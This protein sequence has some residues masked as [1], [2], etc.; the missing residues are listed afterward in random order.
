[1]AASSNATAPRASARGRLRAV[2]EASS[3]RAVHRRGDGTSRGLRATWEIGR[4]TPRVLGAGRSDGR[5]RGGYGCPH[6]LR[7]QQAGRGSLSASAL[8]KGADLLL[9]LLGLVYDHACHFPGH[10]R[11][12]GR[13]RAAPRRAVGSRRQSRSRRRSGTR[14][15]NDPRPQIG[16]PCSPRVTGA[17]AIPPSTMPT[18]FAR[19][20]AAASPQTRTYAQSGL[21]R[22]GTLRCR[23]GEPFELART[24]DRHP[25]S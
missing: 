6:S 4:S 10:T 17:T 1:M 3:F 23:P 14:P 5:E 8:Q 9:A 16:S 7:Q 13:R 21:P 11:S 19:S 12:P 2:P 18:I 25:E 15:V 24:R 22:A 20:L